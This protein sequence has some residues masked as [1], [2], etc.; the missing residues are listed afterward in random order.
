[1]GATKAHVPSTLDR[2]Y[3]SAVSLGTLAVQTPNLSFLHAKR[4]RRF[5][6]V[7]DQKGSSISSASAAPFLVKTHRPDSFLIIFSSLSAF[8]NRWI[9]DL[10]GLPSLVN[11]SNFSASTASEAGP[12]LAGA[13]SFVKCRGAARRSLLGQPGGPCHAPLPDDFYFRQEICRA[14]SRLVCSKR[15]TLKLK[16][17]LRHRNGPAPFSIELGACSIRLA[18]TSG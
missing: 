16:G 8:R 15:T 3:R 9:S 17:D 13:F 12:R 11:H 6:Y 4:Y 10:Y 14:V 5:W 2:P 7:F 1:V 18:C